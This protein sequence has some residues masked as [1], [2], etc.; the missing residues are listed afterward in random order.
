[1]SPALRD[2]IWDTYIRNGIRKE[3][4]NVVPSVVQIRIG[5]SKVRLHPFRPLLP[6]PN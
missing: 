1:M 6:C 4:N 5:G 3:E 2:E